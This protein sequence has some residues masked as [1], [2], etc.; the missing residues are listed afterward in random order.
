VKV[1]TRQRDKWLGSAFVAVAVAVAL[2]VALFL[3]ACAAGRATDGKTVVGFPVGGP[4]PESITEGIAAVAGIAGTILPPPFGTIA[5]GIGAIATAIGGAVW[6]GTRERA[7]SQRA[8]AAY[9]EGQARAAARPGMVYHNA[10]AD[11]QS[12]TSAGFAGQ[13]REALGC[14]RS[15]PSR[16]EKQHD[17]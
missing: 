13:G 12:G 6:G 11:Q 2:F 1:T 10:D 9:D 14:S 7:A 17:Q 4:A 16:A 5:I 15:G 3:T 8:D